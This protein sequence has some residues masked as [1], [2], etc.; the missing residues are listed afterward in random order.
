MALA[1]LDV[2]TVNSVM[3][4]AVAQDEKIPQTAVRYQATPKNDQRCDGCVNWMPPNACKI[5]AGQVIPAGWCIAF[6]PKES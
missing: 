3:G 5:V 2:F 6:A 1:G 4:R